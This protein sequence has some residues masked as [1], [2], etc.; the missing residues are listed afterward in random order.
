[1]LKFIGFVVAVAGLRRGDDGRGEGT[2]EGFSKFNQ[3]HVSSDRGCSGG[4]SNILKK[5][6]RMCLTERNLIYTHH[7]PV[8]VKEVRQKTN[9]FSFK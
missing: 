4:S 6:Y 7:T 2:K 1:M 5:L 9:T 3:T 8:E